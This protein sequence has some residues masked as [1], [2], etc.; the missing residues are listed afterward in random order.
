M[1]TK[2][3]IEQVPLG[4]IGDY[5]LSMVPVPKAGTGEPRITIDFTPVNKYVNR[6]GY[7]TR[8]PEEEIAQ[9]PGMADFRVDLITVSLIMADEVR[10]MGNF[11]RIVYSDYSLKEGLHFQYLEEHA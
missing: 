3:I 4:E 5:V 1:V 2:D 10:N 6:H 7:P 11:K 9:I 8:T